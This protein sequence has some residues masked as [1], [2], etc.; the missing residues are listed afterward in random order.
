MGTSGADY[1]NN[2]TVDSQGDAYVTGNFNNDGFVS[3]LD[4]A[5]GHVIWCY[6]PNA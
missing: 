5:D 6:L 1:A 3:R 2:I 4:S